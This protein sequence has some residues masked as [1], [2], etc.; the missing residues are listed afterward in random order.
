MG[1]FDFLKR[2]KGEHKE[3]YSGAT[4]WAPDP[5][6]NEEYQAKRQAEIDWLEAH[7]DLSSAKGI[8]SIPE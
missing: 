1:L 2:R 6:S 3:T 8:L 7:Y 4:Y 5:I